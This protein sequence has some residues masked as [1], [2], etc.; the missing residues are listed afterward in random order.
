MAAKIFETSTNREGNLMRKL[1]IP[2]FALIFLLVSSPAWAGGKTGLYLGGSF[3]SAGLDVSDGDLK[4]NDRDSAYKIFAGY[5]FGIVPLVNLALEG[6][7]VDFGTAEERLPGGNAETKVRGWDAFGL[8]GLNL[9]PVSLFGKA[10]AIYWNRDSSV[11][12]RST[13]ESGTN[14]AYGLGLQFQLFSFAI[15]AEYEIFKLEGVDIGLASA[16]LSYTF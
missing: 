9:G 3:G 2:G 11:L 13:H 10:G 15:R 8:V 4:Y 7:Y 12:S 16:G 6:S 14:P 5:N 1:T